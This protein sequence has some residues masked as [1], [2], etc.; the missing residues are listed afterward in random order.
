[1]QQ[2]CSNF[3]LTSDWYALSLIFVEGTFKLRFKKFSCLEAF[4][5]MS[6]CLFHLRL[7][8]MAMPKYFVAASRS[9]CNLTESSGDLM[10]LYM[11]LSSAKSLRVKKERYS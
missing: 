5:V 8:C 10:C 1:V 6:M 9:R 2:V 11:M 4:V 7:F 3:G